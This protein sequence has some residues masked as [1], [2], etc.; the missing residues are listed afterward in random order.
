MKIVF[1]N[2]IFFIISF[3][4]QANTYFV[5]KKGADTNQGTEASPWLTIQKAA[6]TLVAGD[7]VFI[8]AGKYNERVIIQN[9]G[10]T[11]NYILFSN[12]QNDTVIINGS[13]I[14]WGGAWNGLIDISNKN[15]IIVTGLIIKNADYGGIWVD[16]SNHI[17][18]KN[19]C[20]YN[21]Y[22]C[23]IGIWNSNFVTVD[24]NEVELACNDGEQ[25][26]ISV[27]NSGNCLVKNNNVHDNGPGTE[28]GE[29]IDIKEG[30]HDIDVYR[31]KVHHL[32]NR[33]GIYADAWNRHTYNINIYQN[34][35]HHCSETGLAVASENGGL[36]ENVTISNNIIYY[37]K[38]GGIELGDWSDIGFIGE[39]P[40]EHVKITNN[41]CYRNGKYDGGWGYGIVVDNPDAADITIRNNICSE[42]NAQIAIQQIATGAIVDHNLL[43]G[44]NNASGTLYGTDYIVENPLFIDTAMYNFHLQ[45]NSPAIDNGS[46]EN[47]SAFDFDGFNR[48]YGDGFDIGAYEYHPTLTI[49]YNRVPNDIVKISPNPVF[50]IFAIIIKGSKFQNYTLKLFNSDGKLVRET[51]AI[52][53]KNG[54]ISMKRNGLT[55]GV[56]ILNVMAD[57]QVIAN[58]KLIFD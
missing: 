50:D 33:L 26:C 54:S 35:I 7:T 43:F 4:T 20:T 39:K 34:I 44:N 55:S 18:I 1:L 31:N 15:Y 49:R 11:D 13:G 36:I 22:S 47:V 30:S 12:F 46:P 38:Y 29:G 2:V 8:K 57:N 53:V 42:N 45:N 48:P 40:I 32:N 19:N 25:E 23:G 41:T 21:T 5:S 14:A 52:K 27:A 10:T 3:T 9:S 24:S 51:K 58:K 16:S 17:I 6:S 56:Y 37:N 28:G